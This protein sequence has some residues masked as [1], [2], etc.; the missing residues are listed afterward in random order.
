[1]I[2]S[3]LTIDFFFSSVHF[4][5]KRR[6]TP[7]IEQQMCKG[8]KTGARLLGSKVDFNLTDPVFSNWVNFIRKVS[9][10]NCSR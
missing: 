10:L 3:S 8:H 2:F 1:M 7:L 6:K 9:T 4:F 5:V